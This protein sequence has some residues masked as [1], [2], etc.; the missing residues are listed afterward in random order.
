M[1]RSFIAAI[2]AAIFLI[3]VTPV[4]AQKAAPN[5]VWTAG[6]YCLNEGAAELL[7]RK[8]IETGLEGYVRVILS[9]GI[10]CWDSNV[11]DNVPT[12]DVRILEKQWQVVTPQGQKFD[13][14]TAVDNDGIYGWVWFLIEDDSV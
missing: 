14:W 5:E 10:Q 13:F 1:V 7:S 2:T 9:G 3:A 8:M 4:S 12:P 11:T 6:A